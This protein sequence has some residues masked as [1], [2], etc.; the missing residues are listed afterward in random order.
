MMLWRLAPLENKRKS[1]LQCAFI[2]LR[3]TLSLVNRET[4]L[5]LNKISANRIRRTIEKKSNKRLFP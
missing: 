5:S 2:C 3:F 1:M 4:F